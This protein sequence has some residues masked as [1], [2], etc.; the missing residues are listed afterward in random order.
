MIVLDQQAVV[1]PH[2]V[3][4]RSA[5]PRRIFLEQ[6]Q[7]RDGLARVEQRCAGAGDR[8]DIA[9][10]QRG[11]AREMLESV[12][13]RAFGGEHGAG[14]A[15]EAHQ[16]RPAVAASPS[17]TSSSIS[18]RV[19]RTEKRRWRY[20]DRRRRSARAFISAVKRAPGRSSRR[21]HVAARPK[22]SASTRLTNSSD[23]SLSGTPCAASS[24][25]AP[26]TSSV[27][28]SAPCDAAR[29]SFQPCAWLAGRNR[30]RSSSGP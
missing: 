24:G 28:R 21:R 23:R 17:S 29:P 4:L 26:R 22:S 13:R 15:V 11:D 20:R 6:A 7:A 27:R 1:E 30:S 9:A 5:H 12:E 18:T 10:G 2:A 25:A 3:V 19:E 16:D 14:I 8:V